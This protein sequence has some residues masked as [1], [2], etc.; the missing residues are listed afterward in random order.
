MNYTRHWRAQIHNRLGSGVFIPKRQRLSD[1]DFPHSASAIPVRDNNILN[2]FVRPHTTTP[3][4]TDPDLDL[5]LILCFKFILLYI[6]NNES[7]LLL[8]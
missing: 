1:S 7:L 3:V 5:Y 6:F 4:D 2:D 8:V